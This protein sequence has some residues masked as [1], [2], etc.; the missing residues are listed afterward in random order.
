M[1]AVVRCDCVISIKIPWIGWAA[2]A[3]AQT[4]A[5]GV[6]RREAKSGSRPQ[7][8]LRLQGVVVCIAHVL[9]NIHRAKLRI[10]ND[11]VLAKSCSPEQESVIGSA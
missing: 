7:S 10:G 4:F 9:L 5:E 2:S 3:D 6:G 1:P 8:D 11:E